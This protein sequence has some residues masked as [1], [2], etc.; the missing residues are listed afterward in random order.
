MIRQY[1]AEY[2]IMSKKNSRGAQQSKNGREEFVE[3]SNLAVADRVAILL[4]SHISL[5]QQ[6]RPLLEGYLRAKLINKKVALSQS[7][8]ALFKGKETSFSI[9]EIN[10]SNSQLVREELEK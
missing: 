3:L 7:F 4:P 10:E 1:R 8:V 6:N 5:E 2:N 9:I